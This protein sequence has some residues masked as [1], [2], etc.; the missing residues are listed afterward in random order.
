MDVTIYQI[1]E[2]NT[3]HNI[4]VLQTDIEMN[5]NPRL[6]GCIQNALESKKFPPF[7]FKLNQLKCMSYLLGG[8]DVIGILPTGFGKS[9]I[10]QLLPFIQLRKDTAILGL[11]VFIFCSFL[12]GVP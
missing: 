10:Y 11:M 2:N 5:I 12:S 7:N 3:I 9:L 8:H 1:N 4:H 6:F